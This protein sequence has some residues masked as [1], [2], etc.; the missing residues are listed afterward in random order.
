MLVFLFLDVSV[1][2]FARSRLT[3]NRIRRNRGVDDSSDSDIAESP[4][5]QS[6][7][8]EGLHGSDFVS[9][10][11]SMAVSVGIALKHGFQAVSLKCRKAPQNN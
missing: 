4:E 11:K 3:Q 9:K 10:L 2:E 1:F 6:A 5:T 7:V 8:V